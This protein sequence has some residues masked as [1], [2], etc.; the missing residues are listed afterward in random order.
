MST[1]R[2]AAGRRTKLQI[3]EASQDEKAGKEL[4]NRMMALFAALQEPFFA[5]GAA[6]PDVRIQEGN[7]GVLQDRAISPGQ[8]NAGAL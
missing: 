4:G 2:A 3:F 8:S 5:L 7:R 1:H 6:V